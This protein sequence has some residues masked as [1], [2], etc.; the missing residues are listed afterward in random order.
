MICVGVPET[1]VLGAVI[2]ILVSC[3]VLKRP[4]NHPLESDARWIRPHT[5][6]ISSIRNPIIA[7]MFGSCVERLVVDV[8]V[9]CVS[10]IIGIIHEYID[11]SSGGTG[12]SPG[13]GE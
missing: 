10:D 13:A 3:L 8:V 6:I 2:E 11:L 5:T 9:T 7:R 12:I 4:E 1:T